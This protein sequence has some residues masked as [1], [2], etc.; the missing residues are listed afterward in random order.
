MTG[1]DL[2]ANSSADVTSSPVAGAVAIQYDL[3]VISYYCK[4]RSSKVRNQWQKAIAVAEGS[5]RNDMRYVGIVS[6]VLLLL[7]LL[8]NL[9]RQLSRG[10]SQVGCANQFSDCVPVY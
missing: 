4:L 2:L 6:Y 1:Q 5:S 7:L 3:M 9:R 10:Q 8:L